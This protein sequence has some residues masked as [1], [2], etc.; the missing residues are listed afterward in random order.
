[1]GMAI[2]SELGEG[3]FDLWNGWSA[4]GA[5]Y[6]EADARSVWRSIS[7]GGAV[8]VAS[9]FALARDNGW[10]DDSPRPTSAELAQ[11]RR[12]AQEQAASALAEEQRR[13]GQ[14]AAQATLAWSNA[15]E[16]NPNHPY[17]LRKRIAPHGARQLAGDLLVPML[18]I[19]GA[20]WNYQ[21]I[22]PDG[23]KRFRPGRAKGLCYAIGQIDPAKTLV[24]CEGFATG[25]TLHEQ[26]GL[27]VLCSFSASNLLPV[28]QDARARWP[29]IDLLIAGDDDRTTHGN[30][31]R[32][33][34]TQAAVQTRA[35]LAFPEFEPGEPGSDFNDYYLNRIKGL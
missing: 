29:A 1:M 20:L 28:A 19:D 9:L 33:L 34:A 3:G 31:G 21:R 14:C 17:L 18:D 35:R 7:A 22:A 25:A 6:R 10:Q 27:P 16:A 30:P 13:H 11:R 2:K 32:T 5:S 26:A 4:S 12:A 24:L 15:R 8:T 23:A